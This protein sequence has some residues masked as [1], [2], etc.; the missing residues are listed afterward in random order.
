MEDTRDTT[1]EWREEMTDKTNT[2]SPQNKT[3]RT[4][5]NQNE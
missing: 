5:T 2:K 1:M 4:N 3:T